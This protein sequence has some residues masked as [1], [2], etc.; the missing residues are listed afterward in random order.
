MTY[1]NSRTVHVWLKSRSVRNVCF[2]VLLL[3]L[4]TANIF[5]QIWEAGLMLTAFNT[6][7]LQYYYNR[8]IITI[9]AV[10]LVFQFNYD[11]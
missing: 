7:I 10:I 3:T 2:E 5:C 9:T 6:L 4:T 11:C 8:N 1:E